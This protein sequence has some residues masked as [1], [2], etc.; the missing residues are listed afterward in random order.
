MVE[1]G[2]KLPAAAAALLARGNRYTC[3]TTHQ[4]EP[5]FSIAKHSKVSASVITCAGSHTFSYHFPL[6]RTPLGTM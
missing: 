5:K 6:A 2:G 1:V 3:V 4:F